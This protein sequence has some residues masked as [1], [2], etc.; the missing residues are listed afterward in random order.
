M[1]FVGAA[2]LVG[3]H[4]DDL[5]ALHFSLERAADSAIG[6]CGQHGM[7]GLAVL[8]Y[9]LLGQR[10][11]RAS[12]HAGAAGHAFRRQ[13]IESAGGHFRAEAAPL[14]GQ[15]EGALNFLAGTHAARAD[16]ALGF[17]EGEIG[18]AFVFRRVEV[19]RA[20]LA[21][22]HVAQADGAGHF[23]ELAIAVGRA[24]QAIQ[25]MVGD[26]EFHHA[27]AQLGEPGVLRADDHAVF[28]RRR[29]RGGRA[30]TA[31][32]LD[33]AQAAR[34][35]RLERIRRA[36]LGDFGARAHGRRHDGRSLRHAHAL[37]VDDERDDLFREADRRAGV[38]FLDQS[39]CR[40]PIPRPG[41]VPPAF[42]NPRGNASA[43]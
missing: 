36:E 23:L 4:V 22:A 30:A 26:V 18:V 21:V 8:D 3:L 20:A 19:V 17:V 12:L 41:E 27:L 6:A 37:A 28:G 13:E 25:R 39:H 14:N 1:A 32:D 43:R 35:K 38:E 34:A 24:G 7:V 2:G 11:G 9:G 10:R 33:E 29:A 15:R 31:L 5:A 40:A 16:D 42:R